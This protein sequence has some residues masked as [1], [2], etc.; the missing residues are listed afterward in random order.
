MKRVEMKEQINPNAVYYS[1]E[2]ITKGR[3][4][5]SFTRLYNSDFEPI[6]D[7]EVIYTKSLSGL[8]RIAKAD[9][10]NDIALRAYDLVKL[11][12][13]FYKVVKNDDTASALGCIADVVKPKNWE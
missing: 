11:N 7:V 2:Y 13:D 12:N 10:I 1:D 9:R 5:S 6:E 8:T 4:I 3:K